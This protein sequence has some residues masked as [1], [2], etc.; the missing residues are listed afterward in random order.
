MIIP[1][2]GINQLNDCEPYRRRASESAAFRGGGYDSRIDFAVGAGRTSSPLTIKSIRNIV[3]CE[4][5]ETF[6]RHR[7]ATAGE[8]TKNHR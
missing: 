8:K 2:L 1:S 6:R 4:T 5:H 3:Y 7:R